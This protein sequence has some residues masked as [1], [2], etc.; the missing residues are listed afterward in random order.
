[1]ART[2]GLNKDLYPRWFLRAPAAG[3]DEIVRLI[4]AADRRED[5]FL[6]QCDALEVLKRSL[7]HDLLTGRVRAGGTVRP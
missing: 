4:R 1:M 3:Q 2:V 6:A 5:V 7:M